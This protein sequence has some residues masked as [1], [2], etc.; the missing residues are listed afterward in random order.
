M[1]KLGA[2]WQSLFSVLSF[3]AIL[4]V[5]NQVFK[6]GVLGFKPIDT[7]YLYF[8]LACY[9]SAAFIIYPGSSKTEDR[10]PW[11]DMILVAL[12]V[13]VNIYFG[14]HALDIIQFGWEYSAPLVPT[15]FAV[16]LWVLVLEGV[17][18]SSGKVLAAI[19][20]VFSLFPIFT[21][22]LPGFLEGQ[23]FDF[24]TTARI[25]TMSIN[26]ILG[27]PFTVV[28]TLLVGFMFFGVVLS[29]TG[30]GDFFFAL[31]EALLGHARGG[32]AKVAV[33]S[34]AF[35]GS[36]SGSAISNVVTTGTLTIPAMKRIGY[37]P[38][39]AGAVEACASTGG[40]I[41]PP[42][43]GAAA[44]VMASFLGVTYGEIVIAAIIPSLLYYLGLLFQVDLHARKIGLKGAPKE[45]LPKLGEVIKSGW[46]Y[47]F[48][49][50]VLV[51]L[52]F[53]MRVE[54]WAPFYASAL[55]LVIANIKKE[56][57]L[58]FAKLVDIINETGKVLANLVTILAAVGLLVGSL[59]VTGVAFSF[60]RELVMSVQG[61]VLLLL[62]FG[63]LTSFILG[64]GMTSTAVYIFL[65][66]VMVPALVAV[67]IHPI[68][69][70]FFVL[71]WGIVSY[72]TPPVALA[73]YAAASIAKTS[74]LK[75]GYTA[76]KLGLVT[77][78]V[79]FMFV[80]NPVLLMQGSPG[81]ILYAFVSAIAGVACLAAGLEGEA[82]FM[83][84]L[85]WFER[86]LLMAAGL[87]LMLSE[88]M[89]D[90][91]GVILIVSVILSTKIIARPQNLIA[92]S[93]AMNPNTEAN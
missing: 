55:L 48:V 9:L 66:I 90:I 29:K 12:S 80:Y 17:R 4:L 31:A 77:Y 65:A 7:G 16:I 13:V 43:M 61:N 82:Y 59:S 60:S 24:I 36:L 3:I 42:I 40:T 56:T 54:A 86:A 11:Y 69:A 28:G 37:A 85:L 21:H 52:L 70:H 49:L 2:F 75:T 62:L 41:M 1:R 35:F 91:G 93:V 51:Y 79:P 33:I 47:L 68:A 67:D 23:P 8:L 26:S 92:A 78:F 46:Y 14:L 87:M 15:V 63:A 45:E 5:I 72:I 25:H 58:N 83:G 18:R 22:Y 53:N 30:G 88:V 44:F 10:M 74:P 27:V 34:S 20:L 32:P 39:Y 89:T 50:I 73:A 6:L 38:H 71:Y 64:F 81:E 19:C 84:R 57:R 76:M